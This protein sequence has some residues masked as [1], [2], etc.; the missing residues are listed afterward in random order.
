MNF[1]TRLLFTLVAA[2][3]VPLPLLAETMPQAT[4]DYSAD[5]LMEA[6]GMTINS[7]IYHSVNKDRVEMSGTGANSIIINRLDKKVGWVLMPEQKTYMEVDLKESKKNSKDISD[8]RVN[9]KNLGSETVNGFKTTKSKINMTCPD[10]MAYEG[11]MWVTKEG[12]L[13]KMDAVAKT[14]DGDVALKQELKNLK[15]GKQNPK[16]FEIPAGYSKMSL[17]GLLRGSFGFSGDAPAR[18][19]NVDKYKG[20][21]DGGRSYTAKPRSKNKK[22]KGRSYTSSSRNSGRSYTAQS[23][24]DGR[25]YTASPRDDG[26]SYTAS[27]RDDGRSYTAESRNGRSYTSRKRSI[28][29]PISDPVNKIRN[30]LGF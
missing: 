15:V 13:M 19:R 21:D 10:N 16:L 9:Q 6:Q 11:F 3:A 17:G 27:P 29:N 25:S 18:G 8:C 14:D 5:S 7:R 28:S 4:V 30:F 20:N 22:S 24:D 12:I 1:V 23:R 2:F 26:R